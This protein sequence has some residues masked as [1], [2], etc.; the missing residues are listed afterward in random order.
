M[1]ISY[2]TFHF[3]FNVV[4]FSGAGEENP[5]PLQTENYGDLFGPNYIKELSDWSTQQQT[6][7]L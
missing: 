5:Y 4:Y 3:D 1:F 2:Q 6:L 7:M